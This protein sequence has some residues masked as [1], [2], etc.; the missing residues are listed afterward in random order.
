MPPRMPKPEMSEKRGEIVPANSTNSTPSKI[1]GSASF[2]LRQ[3]QRAHPVPCDQACWRRSELVVE[4]FQRK[5]T[6]IAGSQ[7]RP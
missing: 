2:R 6:A 5:R 4:D 3:D 7:R 1:G